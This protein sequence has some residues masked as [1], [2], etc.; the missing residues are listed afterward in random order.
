MNLSA[1]IVMPVPSYS[2]SLVCPKCNTQVTPVANY[3]DNCG[4]PLKPQVTLK[5]CP[6]CKSRIV[7]AAHFCPECG[8]KQKEQC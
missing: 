5:I 4:A 7:E 1:F 8:Q 2:Q 6:H 3:C